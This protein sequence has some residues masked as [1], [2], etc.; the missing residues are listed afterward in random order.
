MNYK[1]VVIAGLLADKDLANVSFPYPYWRLPNAHVLY[2]LR[3]SADHYLRAVLEIRLLPARPMVSNRPRSFTVIC[4]PNLVCGGLLPGQCIDWPHQGPQLA[5][6][7]CSLL[8]NFHLYTLRAV[9]HIRYL[10]QGITLP[11]CSRRSYSRLCS[12]GSIT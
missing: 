11:I 8:A 3:W 1:I 12:L 4:L 5:L 2:L 7:S 6:S 10:E 9:S